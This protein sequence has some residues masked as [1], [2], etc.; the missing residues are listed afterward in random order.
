[1]KHK[2]VTQILEKMLTELEIKS[3][4]YYISIQK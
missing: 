1:M 3:N 4:Q 2:F